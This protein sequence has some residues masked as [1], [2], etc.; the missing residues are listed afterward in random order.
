V[1][2]QLLLVIVQTCGTDDPGGISYNAF[3]DGSLGGGMPAVFS[4]VL[5]KEC[6]AQGLSGT[7]RH[8]VVSGPTA[9]LLLLT[10]CFMVPR[11]EWPP[12]E[13]PPSSSS[14]SSES[15]SGSGS[16]SGSSRSEN[17]HV[18]DRGHKREGDSNS[19]SSS[20]DEEHPKPRSPC[21]QV[22]LSSCLHHGCIL[23]DASTGEGPGARWCGQ[24]SGQCRQH[25][26][27]C[28]SVQSQACHRHV[29]S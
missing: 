5:G 3:H 29:H 2:L 14:G 28:H 26:V 10:W 6:S 23:S 8:A 12:L 4:N 21:P 24:H 27:Q 9:V 22:D 7:V 18:D 20:S 19:S 17:K 15:G 25:P 1:L 16:G 11:S 13:D